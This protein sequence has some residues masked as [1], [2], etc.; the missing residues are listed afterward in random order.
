MTRTTAKQSS[1]AGAGV[2]RRQPLGK[3]PGRASKVT[4]KSEASVAAAA[5]AGG[6]GA[7]VT[8][9]HMSHGKR[10]AANSRLAEDIESSVDD[11]RSIYNSAVQKHKREAERIER[12]EDLRR[13]ELAR[14]AESERRELADQAMDAALEMLG[15]L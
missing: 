13:K 11:L 14:Q 4:K 12:I 1:A 7:A 8:S 9:A 6:G 3:A 2:G 5:G 10:K 15:A